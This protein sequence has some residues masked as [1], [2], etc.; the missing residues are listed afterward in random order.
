MVRR[1]LAVL[2]VFFFVCLIAFGI[3]ALF[4]GDFYTPA[5]FGRLLSGES[6]SEATAAID[7]LRVEAGMDKP[8]IVQFWVWFTGV[9]TQGDFGVSWRF[10]FRAQNGLGWTLTIAASSM[11]WAWVVGIPIGIISGLKRNTWIDHLLSVMT[12][13]GF[14]MPPYVWGTLFFVF[15]ATCINKHVIGP[16][17]WGLVG[18][19]LVGEPLTWYKAGS[20]ILHLL[21]AWVIVGSPLFATVARHTRISISDTLSE[22]YITVARGKGLRE[23]CIVLRHAL[24]NALNPLISIFG[25]MLPSMVTSMILLAPVLGYRSFGQFLLNAARYQ[26]QHQLIAALLIYASFLIL[27]NLVADI[28]LLVNDPRIRYT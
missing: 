12:Y 20:H 21:P 8:W 23:R 9:I 6:L 2:P 28:L 18:Y 27:G 5:L 26:K 19:E 15:M 13:I 11:V 24:R 22:Q 4:P 16:G 17:I 14:S 25:L 10:I 7:A 3:I 1:I